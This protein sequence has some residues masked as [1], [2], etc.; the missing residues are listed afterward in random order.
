MFLITLAI[1]VAVL[2]VAYGVGAYIFSNHFLPGTSFGDEDVSMM[3]A[4]EIQELIDGQVKGYQLDV[5]GGAFSY[6]ATS[7][8][9]GLTV[10]SAKMAQEMLEAQNQ[11]AWPVL[12]FQGGHEANSQ[13]A[14]TYDTDGLEKAINEKVEAYNEGATPSQNATIIYDEN[15]DA[16]VVQPDVTGTQYQPQAV[17]DTAEGAI[18]SLTPFVTLT[19]EQLIHADIRAG[20]EKLVAASEAATKMVSAHLRLKLDGTEAGEIGPDDLHDLIHFDEDLNLTLDE[21]ELSVWID[22][23]VKRFDT[24]GSERSYTRPDGKEITV[25]G[26]EYGWQVD[27]DA[28]REA[29]YDC[30]YNGTDTEMDVPC[31]QTAQVFNGQ[32]S[33]DWGNRYVDVDLSEQYVRFYDENSD[34]IWE[35]PCI[36]GVPDGEHDTVVGVWSINNKESPSKLIGRDRNGKKEYE[37]MV[38][39]WMAFEQNSIGFHDAT[40]Q[41]SFGGEM[42]RQ[43]YGSHGCVNLPYSA[44][45]EL[46]YIIDWD[47]VVIVHW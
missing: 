41:P 34:I 6:R 14:L 36:T 28:L 17:I 2:A 37:T 24:V 21:D 5:V 35:S 33:P 26:G 22:G 25:S 19:D 9:L 38:Q 10:D 47:D 42:Y 46:Y 11:W 13:Y 12:I 45:E 1:I 20:D 31:W 16:F 43:G 15:T 3:G 4:E 30:V 23:V 44:A 39:Y 18:A 29:V 27:Q 8:E 7:E 40:W 32:G